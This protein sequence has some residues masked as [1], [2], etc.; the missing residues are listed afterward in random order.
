MPLKIVAGTHK[1]RKLSIPKTQKIRPATAR[2][3]ESIF[4]ILGN[5]EGMEVL[6]LFA[7]TGSV[8]LEALSRGANHVVFVDPGVPAVKLLLKNLTQTEFLDR[9]HV[10]KKRADAA[11][12]FLFKKNRK[13]DLI[14]LDPPY[15]KG[16]IDATLKQLNR[17]SLL[18]PEGEIVCEHSPREIP[19]FLSGLSLVDQRKYGQT[20]VSFLRKKNEK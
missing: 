10:L 20:F 2:V 4:Q 9:A 3:R 6:D 12:E 13:F 18:S 19:T 14:F 15:D 16:F 17:F 11:I 5:L 1:G 8:G 7:G